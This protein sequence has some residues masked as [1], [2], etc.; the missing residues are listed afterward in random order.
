MLTPFQNEPLSD[1]SDPGQAAA[2]REALAQ[3][4]RSLGSHRPLIIGGRKVD[5]G[6]RIVSLNPARPA[7]VVGTVAAAAAAQVDQAL[8][9]AWRAFPAWAAPPAR[10]AGGGRR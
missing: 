4:R 3:V 7:E 5:T 6:D 1:F 9:A 10:G 8:D 2:Y